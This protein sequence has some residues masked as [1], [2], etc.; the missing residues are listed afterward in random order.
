MLHES[1]GIEESLPR[2]RHPKE[3]PSSIRRV[4]RSRTG[5]SVSNS[6]NSARSTLAVPLVCLPR[7]ALSHFNAARRSARRSSSVAS[8]G[9]GE[10]TPRARLPIFVRRQIYGSCLLISRLQAYLR[11][12]PCDGLPEQQTDREARSS[13]AAHPAGCVS[14]G[15]SASGEERESRRN[16]SQHAPRTSGV[17]HGSRLA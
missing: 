6:I 13:L 15:F 7:A 9:T 10:S 17:T 16:S 8:N 4:Q 2:A 11:L 5:A 12:N 14:S 1:F 3:A